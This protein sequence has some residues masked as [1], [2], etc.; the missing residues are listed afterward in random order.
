MLLAQPARAAGACVALVLSASEA[1][2]IEAAQAIR[3]TLPSACPATEIDVQGLSAITTATLAEHR[4]LVAIGAQAA[5]ALT[6][7]EL[8]RPM[9]HILLPAAAYD[10]LP[11]PCTECA[12]MSGVFI[13]HSAERQIAL[14]RLALPH[15]KRI[16][17]ISGPNSGTFARQLAERASA[18]NFEV[19]TTTILSSDELYP[20][21]Q[22]VLPEPAALFALPDPSVFNSY[23][24]QNILLMT[25]RKQSPVIGFSAA[26]VRAGALLGLYSTPTQVGL[27]AAVQVARVLR[28]ERLLPPAHPSRFE[29]EVNRNVARSLELEIKSG[30]ALGEELLRLEKGGA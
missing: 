22:K 17:L 18:S 5:Q 13:D 7:L 12:Q 21:L 8:P 30:K 27:Q 16:A 11:Q 25:Y 1:P 28:G 24:I 19:L 14:L 15:W 3:N 20:A 4:I 9:L 6:R 10:R 2:Y 26:Y 29:V 23:T